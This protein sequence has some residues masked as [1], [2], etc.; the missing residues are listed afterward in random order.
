MIVFHLLFELPGVL[1]LCNWSPFELHFHG[2]LSVC[3]IQ[4]HLL[5][6]SSTVVKEVKV[7]TAFYTHTFLFYISISSISEQK[8]QK[9]N[10]CISA[11]LCFYVLFCSC[12]FLS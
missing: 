12:Y 9:T 1:S 3:C 6:L 8:K 5:H 7:Y 2:K 10:L 11:F 4:V